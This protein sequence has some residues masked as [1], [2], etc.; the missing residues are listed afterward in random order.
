MRTFSAFAAA[1]AA[2]FEA[3]FH[4]ADSTR[5]AVYTGV[6]LQWDSSADE[7]VFSSASNGG[8]WPLDGRAG[9]Y[10]TGKCM[11]RRESRQY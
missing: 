9:Q 7:Y 11:N 8:F 10:A 3:W 2:E 5:Q 6:Q 1:G 4:L